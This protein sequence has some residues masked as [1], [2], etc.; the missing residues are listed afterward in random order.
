[1]IASIIRWLAVAT[2]GV[3]AAAVV[4]AL[5]TA[6]ANYDRSTPAAD[7]TVRSAPARVDVWFTQEMFKRVGSNTLEVAESGGQRVDGGDSL[8][9]PVDRTHLSIGL[10]DAL[11]PGT[12]AV[13]WR[14]LSAIDGDTADGTFTFTVDPSAIETTPSPTPEAASA[15]PATPSPV[16]DGDSLTSDDAS[17][18][19][20]ALLAAGAIALTTAGSAWAISRPDQPE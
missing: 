17:F 10:A 14:T 18:P 13:A 19:W 16:A 1:M 3:A 5:A 8:L 20:W 4:P 6:H 9:D 12:Y 7:S 11:P 15:A 2:L